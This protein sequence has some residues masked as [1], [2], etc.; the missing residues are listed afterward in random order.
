MKQKITFKVDEY[1]VYP[2]HGV[3]KIKDIVKE[4]IANFELECYVIEFE[5]EK[6]T[7]SI[8][9][10]QAIKSGLRRLSTRREMQD[11]F[12]ILRG[13]V[14]KMKGMWSRRAQEYEEKINTGDLLSIAEVL[15]DLTRDIEDSERS[16][17]ERVIYE[18]ALHRLSSEY[19]SVE[20]ITISES[21]E[22]IISISKDK[23]AFE[24]KKLANDG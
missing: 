18:T 22:K 12:D 20:R 21:V 6:L 2:T 19:A 10:K 5:K 9:M 4:K 16:Y 15:R 11:I 3:G 24:E 17:S 23:I 7:I 1:V 14:K 8:P 13:G